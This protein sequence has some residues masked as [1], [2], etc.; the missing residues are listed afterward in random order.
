MALTGNLDVKGGNALFALPGI[1]TLSKFAGHER[2]S[3]AQ[4]AKRLG[5]RDFPVADWGAL[6]PTQVLCRSI[7]EGTPYRVRIRPP[8]FLITAGL[9]RGITGAMMA[10]VVP[11]FGSL[12]MIGGE[13]DR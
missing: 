12:N 5:G 10:D 1:Q 3:D 6:V 13:C 8:C 11:S 2:L 4:R 9:E 7:L